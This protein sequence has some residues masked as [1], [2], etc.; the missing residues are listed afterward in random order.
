[1]DRLRLAELLKWFLGAVLR[2]YHHKQKFSKVR[3][4]EPKSHMFAAVTT[5]PNDEVVCLLA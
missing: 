3:A 5:E 1:M 2:P 4:H